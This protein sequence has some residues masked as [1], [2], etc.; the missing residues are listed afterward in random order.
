MPT[1]VSRRTVDLSAY[2]DLVVGYI[3]MASCLLGLVVLG[4]AVSA[5]QAQRPADAAVD[6]PSFG[7]AAIKPSRPGDDDHNWDNNRELVEVENFT[8]RR[9]IRTAYGLKSESQVLGGPDWI[10]KQA[11]DI[12]AKFDEAETARLQKMSGPERFSQVLLAMQALLAERFHLRITQDTR[13]LPVYALVV[14]KTGSKLTPSP[15][16]FDENGKPKK[17]DQHSIHSS[18]GHMTAK[19]ISMSALAD[20]FE[21]LPECDRVVNNRTGLSGEYDFKL[22]WA[23][24]FGQGIAPDAPLPG[25]FTALREQL[26]VELRPDKAPIN[27]VVVEAASRPDLD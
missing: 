2:P 6:K 8:L 13:D 25:L 3:G 18:N 20:W 15:P 22:D 1:P 5:G 23:Q 27:V 7:V 17:N 16:Q 21:Y 12:Q 14:A 10:G 26:G 11:F 9:L 24:D 19:A 4:A